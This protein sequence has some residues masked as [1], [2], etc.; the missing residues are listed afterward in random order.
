MWSRL[1]RAVTRD[2][3]VLDRLLGLTDAL[4]AIHY[5]TEGGERELPKATAAFS[6]SEWIWIWTL[7]DGDGDRYRSAEGPVAE[8][9]V[10]LRPTYFRGSRSTDFEKVE[11][12]VYG[13]LWSREHPDSNW[14]QPYGSWV[15]S[16]AD[17]EELKDTWF[18]K[19]LGGCVAEAAH[20]LT[21]KMPD[22][23]GMGQERRS[24]LEGVKRDLPGA[25]A[26][27]R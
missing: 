5:P 19:E 6:G 15:F 14:S 11:L 24:F 16:R 3:S 12:R 23:A 10:S 9:I 8:V 2:D 7:D 20:D 25:V 26:R 4:L 21:T 27:R 13:K 18:R 17:A 22:L 1:R